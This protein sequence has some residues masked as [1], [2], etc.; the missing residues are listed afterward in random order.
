M[1][2]LKIIQ[3]NCSFEET[4]TSS[5]YPKVVKTVI[6]NS[7]FLIILGVS[8]SSDKTDFNDYFI[9]CT[10][11]Y[12]DGVNKRVDFVKN[13]PIDYKISIGS[14]GTRL[15]IEA[16]VKVLSSQHEDMNF[17]ILI[18][19]VRRPTQRSMISL[20]GGSTGIRPGDTNNTQVSEFLPSEVLTTYTSAIKVISKPDQIRKKRGMQLTELSSESSFFTSPSVSG[21]AS[22]ST[23]PL[24]PLS[25]VTASSSSATS[26]P[27]NPLNPSSIASPSTTLS[28]SSSLLGIGAGKSQSSTS[29]TPADSTVIGTTPCE[30]NTNEQQQ[31]QPPLKLQKLSMSSDESKE[32]DGGQGQMLSFNTFS[33]SKYNDLNFPQLTP[34]LTEIKESSEQK[35]ATPKTES[36]SSSSITQLQEL[37]DSFKTCSYKIDKKSSPAQPNQQ[38]DIPTLLTPP[39]SS[40]TTAASSSSSSS[41]SSGSTI[42]QLIQQPSMQPSMEPNIQQ[43]VQQRQQQSQFSQRTLKEMFAEA[44]MRI[45]G[46]QQIGLESLRGLHDYIVKR[47]G[48]NYLWGDNFYSSEAM[49][50]QQQQQQSSA[51]SSAASSAASSATL[52]S[53]ISPPLPPPLL[54]P[55]SSGSVQQ[56]QQQNNG[57]NGNNGGNGNDYPQ[58]LDFDVVMVNVMDA[59][60]RMPLSERVAKIHHVMQIATPTQKAHISEIIDM[61]LSEGLERNLG[62]NTLYPG[63]FAPGMIP[64]QNIQQQQQQQQQ[65]QLPQNQQG[66]GFT[67]DPNFN[68]FYF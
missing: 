57:R 5:G 58:A 47:T 24:K 22:L 19:A 67:D 49:Q 8:E 9:E 20:P 32:S 35:N 54:P 23:L 41:S 52:S 29:S 68:P 42:T 55:L 25:V 60:G 15:Q 11:T 37:L 13:K 33:L 61:F 59:Y 39:Q 14:E 26:T 38:Q 28:L 18:Q 7:P 43:N 65:M 66:L 10:L 2:E 16:K 62:H 36:P 12:D 1:R 6:K 21:S 50:Q 56:Q 64:A 31:Q 63:V 45:E 27:I 48:L 44:L 30:K 40:T 34:L 51:V 17:K 4:V 3:Q 46:Y 53:A